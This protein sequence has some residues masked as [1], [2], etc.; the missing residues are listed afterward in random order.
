MAREVNETILAF[1]SIRLRRSYNFGRAHKSAHLR[2]RKTHPLM[3]V[4]SRFAVDRA[5][6][7]TLGSVQE[8][9]T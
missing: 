5:V 3:R 4:N 2:A 9:K 8:V 1:S 7:I 6:K